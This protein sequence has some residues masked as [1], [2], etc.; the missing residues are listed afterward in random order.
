MSRAFV[1]EDAS[2]P[3]DEGDDELP[4]V[5]GER[6]ITPGGFQRLRDERSHL[7]RHERPK[8]TA[9]VQVA[10][11]HGDRSENADYQYGKRKLREIDRRLR[12]LDRLLEKLVVVT[13][14]KEQEGKV[15]FGA[16]VTVEDEEGVTTEY[17]IVGPD[18]FDPKQRWI[19]VEAP[20]ARAL[21]GRE[22]GDVFEFL[23]PKGEIELEVKGIR[24]EGE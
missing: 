14:R 16:F 6:F 10:A 8:V 20:L 19:S 13:P 17:R 22:V 3:E 15:W 7:L 5:T 2:P 1:K 23:R 24:Y 11:A 12:Y 4:K 21:L 9:E 18:E